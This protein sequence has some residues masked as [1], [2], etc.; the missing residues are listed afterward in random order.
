MAGHISYNAFMNQSSAPQPKPTP[1]AAASASEPA[2][3]ARPTET[4]TNAAAPKPTFRPA[5]EVTSGIEWRPGRF[6]PDSEVRFEQT[7][8]G[9]PGGQHVNKT[10]TRV[11]LIWKPAA[12][13]AFSSREIDRLLEGLATRLTAQGELR[14][15]SSSERSAYRNR[16]E[17]VALLVRLVRDALAPQRKRVAT[18]TPRAAKQKR[19]ETKG[20][21]SRTKQQRRRPDRDAD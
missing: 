4:A 2:R 21:R 10:A 1:R 5:A 18:K 13:V 9:G 12:S 3:G 11:T 7:I 14:L 16:E 8:G 19:L 15:R 20:K 6:I 17:C